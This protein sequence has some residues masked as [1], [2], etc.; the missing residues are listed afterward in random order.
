MTDTLTSLSEIVRS[1]VPD[2]DASL[3]LDTDL[4]SLANFNSTTL[5]QLMVEVELTFN[6]EFIDD[7][8]D[9]AVL[10][11]LGALSARV[12][13]KLHAAAQGA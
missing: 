11:N 12:N 1:L 7:D 13:E 5:V 6:V 8:M 2:C 9:L 4:M 3:G 10:T